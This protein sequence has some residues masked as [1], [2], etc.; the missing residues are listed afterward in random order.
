MP[1]YLFDGSSDTE[2][3]LAAIDIYGFKETLMMIEG[4]F[5]IG[6]WDKKEKIIYSKR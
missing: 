6:C 1:N 2:I 3:L 5:A 4:M